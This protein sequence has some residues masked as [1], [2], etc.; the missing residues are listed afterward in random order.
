MKRVLWQMTPLL[1]RG[2]SAG[3]GTSQEVRLWSH[4]SRASLLQLHCLVCDG[5]HAEPEVNLRSYWQ[6]NWQV[7]GDALL[8]LVSAVRPRRNFV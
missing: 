1:Y 5:M 3:S 7:G 4:I 2:G 6:T 8:V